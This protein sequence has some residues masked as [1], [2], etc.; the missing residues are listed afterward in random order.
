MYPNAK[1][2]VSMEKKPTLS[3]ATEQQIQEA[4]K[5]LKDRLKP[6]TCSLCSTLF[7][8]K[9]QW[10]KFCSNSCRV[11][12]FRLKASIENAEWE[13]AEPEPKLGQQPIEK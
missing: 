5:E 11:I 4:F 10:Q 1:G 3:T 9:R 8:P 6:I 12:Y 2:C 7:K 13:S